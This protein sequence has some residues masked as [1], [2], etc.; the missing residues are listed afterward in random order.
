VLD[1]DPAIMVTRSIGSIELKMNV[2]DSSE[3]MRMSHG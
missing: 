1:Q 3:T 2:N